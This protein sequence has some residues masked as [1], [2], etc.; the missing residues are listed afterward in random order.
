MISSAGYSYI[1]NPFPLNTVS[2]KMLFMLLISFY[3]FSFSPLALF[4]FKATASIILLYPCDLFDLETGL[5][6]AVRRVGKD[7]LFLQLL[8]ER[9]KGNNIICILSLALSH[10]FIY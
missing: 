3:N 10:S 9:P 6:P 8:S 5:L 1:S 2:Q 7:V 4:F